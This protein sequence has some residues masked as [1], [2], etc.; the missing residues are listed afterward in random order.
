MKAIVFA[1]I[2]ESSQS[3]ESNS[4]LSLSFANRSAVWYHLKQY[5]NCLSDIRNAFKYD[6][7]LSQTKLFLR[8]VNCFIQKRHFGDA[9]DVFDSI[10]L[11][12]G[13]D[14]RQYETQIKDL[15]KT[16][17]ERGHKN[18]SNCVNRTKPKTNLKFIGNELMPNGSQSI[19]LC[20]SPS[21]GRHIVAKQDIGVSDVLFVEKPF[22]SVLLPQ[23]YRSYCNHCYK[24][25]SD[26]SVMPCLKCSQVMYCSEQCSQQSWSQYHR[27]ECGFLDVMHDIG[28]AHL[29]LRILLVCGVDTA[30]KVAE[31]DPKGSPTPYLNDYDSVYALVDHSNDFTLED[32]LNYSLVA[33]LLLV[34]TQNLGLVKNQN[35]DNELLGGVLLKHILQL[36]GNGHAISATEN[37]EHSFGL[38]FEDKRIAT[39]IYPTVSLMNHS[40]DPNVSAVYDKGLL[41]VRAAKPI[42]EG[43]EVM[44]CYGPHCK[45]M[46]TKE[47]QIALMEQYFFKC[48][49]N[50][51][52]TGKEDLSRALKCNHCNDAIIS[53]DEKNFC[54]NCK[55]TDFDIKSMVSEVERGLTL[56]SDGSKLIDEQNWT[57][58]EAKLLQSLR[59]LETVLYSKNRNLGK[60][61]D[62]LSRLY[63][64]MKNWSKAVEYCRE[65]VDIVS[66]VFGETSAE[67]MNEL[68]KLSELQFELFNSNQALED[69]IK[70]ANSCLLT[71]S[72]AIK[73]LTNYSVPTDDENCPQMKEMKK[74]EERLVFCNLFVKQFVKK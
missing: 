11:K 69:S 30:L 23:F 72:K 32:S 8:K 65:S 58:S 74:L 50:P 24:K 36:I 54:Q 33:S 70:D 63:S 20:D 39:A 27:F 29:A 22:A 7:P 12:E 15:L 13:S 16:F 9:K 35:K 64:L 1:S 73:L 37:I 49:C 46:S 6:Y 43:Q 57:E 2:P 52:L 67:L 71:T 21:K 66:E 45:R 3:V 26:V 61:L 18:P 59:I 38:A 42:P 53:E 56:L 68:I 19:K 4:E 31:S 25:L 28:I 44:N 17:E 40:C 62:E 10:D 51:C 48:E 60:V 47:R 41:I 5:D 14:N 34:L 55:E